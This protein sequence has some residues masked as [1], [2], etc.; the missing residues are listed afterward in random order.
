M[1]TSLRHDAELLPPEWLPHMAILLEPDGTRRGYLLHAYRAIRPALEIDARRF[2]SAAGIDP[3]NEVHVF[4]REPGDWLKGWADLDSRDVFVAVGLPATEMRWVLA[5]EVGHLA[6]GP[7]EHL[8]D[9][10]AD[11]VAG[12]PDPN[13]RF[14]CEL[15]RLAQV[16][17]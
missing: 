1:N 2:A 16:L 8:A 11:R 5:H 9:V 15:D 10:F 4:E 12:P 7:E 14:L 6:Y 3:P 17:L 13:E